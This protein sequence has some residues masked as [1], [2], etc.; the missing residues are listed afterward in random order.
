[1]L[2]NV[3]L[4]CCNRNVINASEVAT[5]ISAIRAV[6]H[7]IRS[8]FRAARKIP[9]V[10]LLIRSIE[11]SLLNPVAIKLISDPADPDLE[12]AL[13]LYKKRIP[14]DQRVETNDI[15]SWLREDL[16]SRK[17]PDRDSL[18]TDW[19]AVALYRGRVT[20]FV[21]FHYYP[22]VR[23]ALFAY[24]VVA[25][26][27]GVPVTLVSNTLCTF[28]S[29][30]LKKRKE[31]RG[32]T[33]IVLEVEDP[34]KER[35]KPKQEERLARVRRFCTL[36]E[37][38][39]LSL[40]ALDIEYKQPKL[41]TEAPDGSER[42]MLL[43]YAM[44]L[45]QGTDNSTNHWKE[46]AEILS[47]IYTVVYP[48]GYSPDPEEKRLYSEYCARLKEREI[49]ALPATVRS[50]SVKQLAAQVPPAR[51]RESRVRSSGSSK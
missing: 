33:G 11:R 34:R 18:P 14:A 19:F 1:V 32:C 51:I 13:E 27:P 23:L 5:S 30:L 4:L 49:A 9:G 28:V 36:A 16:I 46:A 45:S 8:L 43:L 17:R 25:A 29:K 31:L 26:T 3:A 10:D 20:G 7:A 38:R 15:V 35:S 47:F 48:E 42:P 50:L 37:M 2:A 39:G 24:M 12:S 44:A 40:R 41:T 21:L 6:W 22:L